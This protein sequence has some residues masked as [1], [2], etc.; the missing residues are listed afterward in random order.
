MLS[1]KLPTSDFGLPTPD[2]HLI[3]LLQQIVYYLFSLSVKNGILWKD[4]GQV[5]TIMS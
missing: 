5:E 1:L 3:P 2:S 4:V